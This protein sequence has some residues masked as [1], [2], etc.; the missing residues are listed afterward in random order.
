LLEVLILIFDFKATY[1]ETGS[2]DFADDV[3]AANDA[4]SKL[5]ISAGIFALRLIKM[6]C[7]DVLH[8]VIV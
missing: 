5:V 3:G 2:A 6:V 1:D 8:Q 4:Y 7:N